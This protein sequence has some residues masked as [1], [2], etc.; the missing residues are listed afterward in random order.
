MHQALE[1]GR[2]RKWEMGDELQKKWEMGDEAQKNDEKMWEMGEEVFWKMGDGR[3][4]KKNEW[5]MGDEPQNK[6]EM[7]DGAPG[8][9]PPMKN[10]ISIE[11]QLR[12]IPY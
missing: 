10:S 12:Y 9:L 6:W 8:A 2:A 7:G 11:Y 4:A 3:W 1:G 5:E